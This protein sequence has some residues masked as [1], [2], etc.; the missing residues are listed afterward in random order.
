MASLKTGQL[1]MTAPSATLTA[2]D[3]MTN[4]LYDLAEQV[5][6]HGH[7]PG[8]PQ[9]AALFKDFADKQRIFNGQCRIDFRTPK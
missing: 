2:A 3:D 1:V 7:A 9:F 5:S 6:L 8:S 4:S